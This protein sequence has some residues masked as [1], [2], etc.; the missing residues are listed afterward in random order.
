VADAGISDNAIALA[1]QLG[2]LIFPALVTVIIW[3]LA[4]WREVEH[5]TGWRPAAKPRRG[6]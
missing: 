6:G 1:Y 5:F 2:V 3:V 4:S